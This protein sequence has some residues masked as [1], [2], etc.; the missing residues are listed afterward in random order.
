MYCALIR[1]QAE[2]HTSEVTI[3]TINIKIVK[4]GFLK[5]IKNK[6]WSQNIKF[7][8]KINKDQRQKVCNLWI[9][10]LDPKVFVQI[11][12]IVPESCE[13]S[14]SKIQFGMKLK[15]L[16]MKFKLCKMKNQRKLVENFN[17]LN[18]IEKN[19]CL[20]KCGFYMFL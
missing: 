9:C 15:K 6:Y 7:G 14:W 18:K 20:S 13:I 10:N 5:L 11:C 8:A 16:N 3:G 17:I 12:L 2:S 1:S 19:D 4:L